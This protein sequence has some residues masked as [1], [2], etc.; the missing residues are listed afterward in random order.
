VRHTDDIAKL[1]LLLVEP[2][3]RGLGLGHRLVQECIDFARAA[4]YRQITLWTQA[5]LVAARRIYEKAGFQR[6]GVEKHNLFGSEM[7][8]EVWDMTL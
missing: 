8:G 7:V 4:G 6:T 2:A 1:R 3:A 5:E